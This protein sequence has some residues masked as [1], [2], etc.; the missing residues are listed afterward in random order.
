MV[1]P[2]VGYSPGVGL[3]VFGT[4]LRILG[5]KTFG[6]GGLCDGFDS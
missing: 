3:C 1:G 4:S 6:Y 2:P 5:S